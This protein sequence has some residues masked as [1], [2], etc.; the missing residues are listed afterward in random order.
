MNV[1]KQ[2]DE[3]IEIVNEYFKDF[4]YFLE[5]KDFRSFLLFTLTSQV[6]MNLMAQ[7]GLGGSKDIINLPYNPEDNTYYQKINLMSSGSLI[8]YT[9][10]DKITEKFLLEKDN[11]IFKGFLNTNEIS[12][13]FRGKEKFL[14]PKVTDCSNIGNSKLNIV[15]DDLFYSIDSFI[16]YLQP[17]ILFVLDAKDDSRPDLIFTFNMM[18]QLPTKLDEN[19]LKIDV[20]LDYEHK[21]KDI[22]YIKREEDYNLTFMKDIKEVSHGDLYKS[23]FSLVLHIK[24]LEKPS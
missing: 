10:T 24:S 12:L 13:A 18:P 9:K 15:I 3:K 20:Y 19:N 17:N 14:F 5:L 16:S 23:A 2:L 1:S 8:I 11:E 6:P 4:T 21:T 7:L 22:T